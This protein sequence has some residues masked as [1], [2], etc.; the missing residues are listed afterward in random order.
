MPK[1]YLR[2]IRV[3]SGRKRSTVLV[4]EDRDVLPAVGLHH[5]NSKPDQ[6]VLVEGVQRYDVW[7]DRRVPYEFSVASWRDDRD[8]PSQSHVAQWHDA[9]IAD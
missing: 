7:E 9:V 3:S 5:I 4:G 8:V 6:L 1:T 2:V